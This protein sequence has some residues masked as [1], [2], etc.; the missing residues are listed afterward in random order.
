MARRAAL[1]RAGFIAG[2]TFLSAEVEASSFTY[3]PN[4]TYATPFGSQT[5]TVTYCGFANNTPSSEVAMTG[6]ACPEGYQPWQ[7]NCLLMG[8]TGSMGDVTLA[9][10]TERVDSVVR[11]E[12][13]WRCGIWR[14]VWR[15]EAWQRLWA[16]CSGVCESSRLLE[17]IVRRFHSLAT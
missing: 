1:S 11:V 15:W 8:F 3:A 13:A 16:A 10:R 12:C 2:G 9:P 7:M 5:A 4:L 6:E 14:A 17:R